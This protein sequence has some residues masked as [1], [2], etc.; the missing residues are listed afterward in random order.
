MVRKTWVVLL[1]SIVLLSTYSSA[2]KNEIGFLVG[3][4]SSPD[5]GGDIAIATCPFNFPNCGSS[6]HTTSTITYEGVVAHRIANLH[7]ASFYVELPVLGIPERNTRFTSI[8]PGTSNFF[9]SFST[10]FFTPSVKLKFSLP[11]VS[12]FLSV[13]GGFAHFSPNQN[14]LGGTP[15]SSTEAAFQAGGGVDIGTPLPH[16]ALRGE[17]REFFTGHPNFTTSPNNIFFG[18]GLVLRF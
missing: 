15:Q 6:T 8:V 14:S 9:Q 3:A 17:V 10:I 5:S 2:Q 7:L 18:G 4:T 1:F 16:V 13:G 11:L 12:P